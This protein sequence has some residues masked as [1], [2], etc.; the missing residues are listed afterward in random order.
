MAM[1]V[2]VATFRST[3]AMIEWL[4]GPHFLGPYFV[5]R[6]WF[7]LGIG[8]LAG[9]AALRWFRRQ[10]HRFFAYYLMH[11]YAYSAQSK[12]ANPPELEARM[13]AF[14]HSIADAMT[15]GYDEVLVVGHSSGAH[16][17]VSILAD[18]I[19]QGLPEDAP[20]LVVP[21][22]GAGGADGV[23]PAQSRPSA[24]RSCTICQRSLELT[25]S[26]SPPPAMAVPLRCVI[27]LR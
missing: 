4:N 23:F 3:D 13:T 17:A 16:L 27:R 18:L 19:R 15:Q 26:M 12:G 21:V 25:G 7:T 6:A 9:W 2:W 10:D 11:D 24:R 22:L 5:F 20:A 8:F 14:R 1:L